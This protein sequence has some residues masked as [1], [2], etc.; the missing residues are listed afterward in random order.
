MKGGKQSRKI[1]K[2]PETSDVNLKLRESEEKF[3]TIFENADDCLIYLDKT[4]KILDINKKAV[5]VFGGSKNEIL[6]KH[7][8]KVGLFS[9]KDIPILL[10]NF[11]KI[12]AGKK[13]PVDIIIKNK[14]G[15]EKYLECSASLLKTGNK[16]SEIMVIARDVT[17][18]KKIEEELIRLSNAVK[19]S[20]DSIVISD[21]KGN[22]I[23]VN[24][25]TLKMYGTDDKKYLIGKSSLNLIAP[26]DRKRALA[27]MTETLKRG[28][29]KGREYCIVTKD[30]DTIPV[31]MNVAIMKDKYGK[32]SGFVGINRDITERKRTEK[33]LEELN[34]ELRKKVEELEKWRK[35]TVGRELKMIKLKKKME[36]VEEK[37][38]NLVDKK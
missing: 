11:R 10:N 24:E 21:L 1:K 3:K 14:K 25:A 18:R 17:E 33:E 35:M 2:P 4:G 6:E 26:E 27:G 23:D 34:L 30:G 16:I 28:Y 8:T 19:M 36:K 20:T 9:L 32:P 7:F 15:K 5:N 37:M 13:P 29:V 31:E 38:K 12:L 22:I